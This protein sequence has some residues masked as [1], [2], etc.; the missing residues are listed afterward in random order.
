VTASD[1]VPGLPAPFVP[2]LALA[3]RFYRDA[4]RPILE[5]RFPGLAHSAAL[6]GCG[7]EVLGFD[8]PVSCDH[9]WGPRAIVLLGDADHARQGA[10]VHE[11]LRDALPRSCL[12][13][14]TSFGA[15]DAIGVR[16]LLVAATGPVEHMVEIAT[17]RGW[18]RGYLG[19]DPTGPIAPADWLLCPSQL[20]RSIT[21]GAVFHDDLGLAEV[22]AGLAWYPD[23]VWRYLLAASWQRIGEEEH[24]VG[25]AGQVGDELGAAVIAARLVRDLMRLCF[26]M[27]RDHAPYPKWYGTAFARL[28]IAPA[29][30]PILR[31]ALAAGHWIDRDQA[32]GEAYAVVAARHN[33]LGLTEPLPA[34]PEPFDRYP[35]DLRTRQ[36]AS[37]HDRPF[38][39]IR[40]ERFAEALAAG[41]R[42]PAL[43]AAPR[44][45]GNIDQWSDST[46]LL[47]EGVS[48]R[49]RL[50]AVFDQG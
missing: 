48:P 26:L 30:G 47:G 34:Q 22:R 35:G 27:A 5:A 3:E 32:L 6:I 9:H 12:G 23:D 39:V 20:L 42:D 10:A 19:F 50:R 17:L 40:G 31:R 45:L 38:S 41:I 44:W 25:R 13:W 15:G 16:K 21:G 46:L 11:A 28:A 37:G 33:A 49:P 8:T 24:L 4:I 29:L 18:L 43:R 1:G 14:P 2:G 36:R 7:S